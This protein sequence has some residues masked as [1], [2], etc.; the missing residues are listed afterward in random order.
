VFI[1]A[2]VR[3]SCAQKKSQFKSRGITISS[4]EEAFILTQEEM[5]IHQ[6][7]LSLSR[8]RK[9]NDAEVVENLILL[10]QSQLFKKL[11]KRNMFTYAVDILGHDEGFAYSAITSHVR[12]CSFR[13][14]AR[15]LLQVSFL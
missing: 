8:S 5:K 7:A 10:E 15:L 3:E 2:L 12:A 11:D 14:F 1:V 13:H 4:L 6:Q 9:R